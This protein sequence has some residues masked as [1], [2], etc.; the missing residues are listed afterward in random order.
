MMELKKK[1]RTRK[2]EIYSA[3]MK[4]KQEKRKKENKRSIFGKLGWNQQEIGPNSGSSQG[5]LESK[6]TRKKKGKINQKQVM[7]RIILP[8]YNFYLKKN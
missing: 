8:I 5:Y 7:I 4:G 1:P 6:M 2:K 3:S